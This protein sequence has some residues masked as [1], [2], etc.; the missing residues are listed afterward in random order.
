MYKVFFFPLFVL[1]IFN[2]SWAQTPIGSVLKAPKK[3]YKNANGPNTSLIQEV[4]KNG[5]II[6][7]SCNTCPFVVGSKHFPGWEKQYNELYDTSMKNKIGF[8]LVNSN[9]AK[10]GGDD[11]FDKMETHAKKNKYKMAYLLDENSSL[12]NELLA[13][14]TPHVFFYNAQLELI[15]SGSIDNIWDGKRKKEQYYLK[16]AIRSHVS[17]KKIKPSATPPK[18][19]SIKR[20]KP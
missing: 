6:V 15:Y 14:T 4:K 19:C 1:L 3:L 9:E 10:R 12:A 2:C 11:A 5:L 16:D 7:F 8:L 20:V 17:S 13:K 18:G